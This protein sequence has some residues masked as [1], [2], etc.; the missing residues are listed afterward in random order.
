MIVPLSVFAVDDVSG[1][2]T[3]YIQY[4]ESGEEAQSDQI[5]FGSM[6]MQQYTAWFTS[7]DNLYLMISDDW[8][9]ES[10]IGSDVMNE[11]NNLFAEYFDGT[12]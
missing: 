11:D 7:D 9:F 12:Y 10:Y 5:I 3:L 8:D 1:Y 6:F 2:C 4:L